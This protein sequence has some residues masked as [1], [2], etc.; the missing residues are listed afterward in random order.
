[1]TRRQTQDAQTDDWAA[2]N[3]HLHGDPGDGPRHA[4]PDD[5]ARMAQ[6]F[7]RCNAPQVRQDR[8]RDWLTA[9]RPALLLALAVG[10]TLLALHLMTV[11]AGNLAAPSVAPW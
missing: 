9:L 11:T 10:C 7:G 5:A 6:H 8:L 3:Q 4:R 2:V 1:M